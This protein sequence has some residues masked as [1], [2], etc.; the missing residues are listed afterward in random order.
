MRVRSGMIFLTIAFNLVGTLSAQELTRL[1]YAED[2]PAEESGS[3]APNYSLAETAGEAQQQDDKKLLGLFRHYDRNFVHFISPMTNPVFFED[4]RTLTEARVIFIN[5]HLPSELGGKD[6]QVYAMQLRG[7][8]TENLSL[9]ATKDGYL[10][11]QSD[12]LEDG[13]ADIMGGLK[14]NLY[15]N[16][17]TQ[18]LLSAGLTYAMPFGSTQALQGRTDGEFNFFVTGGTEF[19][20]NWHWVSATGYR[21]P[22]NVPEGNE[23]W[24]WSNHVDWRLGE[25]GF[26]LFTEANWFHYLSSGD[27]FPVPVGGQDFFN[28]GSQGITGNDVVT[29]A[30]GIKYKPKDNVEIGFAYE[31]PY[32]DRR[33]IIGNRVTVDLIFRY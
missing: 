6:V 14:Y 18:T 23:V 16:C 24:Y 21:L 13:F 11:S 33:D 29:G 5:H 27:A 17:E 19:M 3:I 28:L 4:P 10:V 22:S 30:F 7:A 31:F 15:K 2:P 26:Y 25:T 9:I 20:T 12:V 8:I 32:T 1:N